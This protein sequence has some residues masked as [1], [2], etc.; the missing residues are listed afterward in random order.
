MD[1]LN[2]YFFLIILCSMIIPLTFFKLGQGFNLNSN[3]VVFIT[4]E[5]IIKYDT[6]TQEETTIIE[7]ET[8]NEGEKYISFAQ[9]SSDDN[10]YFFCRI[11]QT[12]YVFSEN[13]EIL[14]DIIDN[15]I[16]QASLNIIPFKSN[17]GDLKIIL[18]FANASQY[19][20][21]KSYKINYPNSSGSILEFITNNIQKILRDNAYEEQVLNKRVSCELIYSSEYTQEVLTC[22]LMNGQSFLLVINFNPENIS[23]LSFSK[24]SI[25]TT[26]NNIIVSEVSPDNKKCISCY[27]DYSMNFFCFLYDVE[28]NELSEPVVLM[29]KCM[30]FEYGANI[31]YINEKGEYIG[32]CLIGSSKKNIIKFDENFEVKESEND[33]KY[34]ISFSAKSGQCYNVYSM[35]VL[36]IKSSQDYFIAR[37]CDINNLPTLDLINIS[38]ENAEKIGLIKIVIFINLNPHLFQIKKLQ[39]TPKSALVSNIQMKIITSIS[40]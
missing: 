30:A 12:I 2:F 34:Y 32:Y 15:D 27:I 26:G 5:S 38:E 31:Q 4:T 37:N 29:T 22:F 40:K 18:I 39:L 21:L 35:S 33:S 13:F 28:S 7:Y 17:N 1:Y 19:L 36:Y 20:E 11:K 6:E 3:Y 14:G 9:F 25:K 23:L 24:N 16:E 10:G 8:I